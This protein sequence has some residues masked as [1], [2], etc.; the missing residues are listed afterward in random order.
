MEPRQ[1]VPDVLAEVAHA[2]AGGAAG[3]AK[4]DTGSC[5]CPGSDADAGTDTQSTAAPVTAAVAGILQYTLPDQTGSK[6]YIETKS[7]KH[8]SPTSVK[9]YIIISY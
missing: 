6:R 5:S 3:W 4:P 8:N 1:Q 9:A 2:A 7:T